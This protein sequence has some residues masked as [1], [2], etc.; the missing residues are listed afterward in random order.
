MSNHSLQ[1]I[2]QIY[3][4]LHILLVQ[5]QLSIQF[6]SIQLKLILISFETH[7]GKKV[8]PK[9]NLMTPHSRVP[10]INIFFW[11]LSLAVLVLTASDWLEYYQL[12]QAVSV[13]VGIL[14]EL[15]NPTDSFQCCF[16]STQATQILADDK[17][18]PI[19]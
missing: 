3:I 5:L 18:F 4:F 15:I 13:L 9:G 11:L 6:Y 14:L 12:L 10:K 17:Y 2:L 7:C 8:A 19:H 16:L 1:H